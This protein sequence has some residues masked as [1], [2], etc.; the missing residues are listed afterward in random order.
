MSGCFSK[1]EPTASNKLMR[2]TRC[3]PRHWREHS[4]QTKLR[5]NP[6]DAM[7]AKEARLVNQLLM[8]R[9]QRSWHRLS[10]CH[11]GVAYRRELSLVHSEVFHTIILEQWADL[12]Q[13]RPTAIH[14]ALY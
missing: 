3:C 4:R 6:E 14:K 12:S 9:L 13:T 8:H 10:R 11:D 5:R 1:T 7:R 2:P